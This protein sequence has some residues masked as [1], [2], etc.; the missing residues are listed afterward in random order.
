MPREIELA[1]GHFRRAVRGTIALATS[2]LDGASLPR[3]GRP[4][5]YNDRDQRMMLRHI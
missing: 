2:R 1:I 5:V 4:V 3:S